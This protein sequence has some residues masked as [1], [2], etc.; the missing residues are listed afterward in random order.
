MKEHLFSLTRDDFEF[1]Y[2]RAGGKGGQ[3][4]N[5][6]S[7]GCRVRHLAS[8]AVAESREHRQQLQ[9]KRAAWS[10]CVHS[11]RFTNWLRVA[12]ARAKMTAA[13]RYAV[14]QYLERELRGDNPNI[15]VEIKDENGD[16]VPL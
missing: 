9:N 11:P 8:G 14:D 2:F 6:T 5:K 1:E 4:Q 13:H 12:T 10:K 15:L 16:W 7:S 3:A